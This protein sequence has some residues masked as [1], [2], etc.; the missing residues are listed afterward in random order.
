[1][2]IRPLAIVERMHHR[3]PSSL[4]DVDKPTFVGTSRGH[5]QINRSTPDNAKSRTLGERVCNADTANEHQQAAEDFGEP[6]PNP[7][8]PIAKDLKRSKRVFLVWLAGCD[9][10]RSDHYTE[11]SPRPFRSTTQPLTTI[12]MTLEA[13]STIEMFISRFF[14]DQ[15]L[16]T[17]FAARAMATPAV[18]R[19]LVSN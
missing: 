5:L 16:K 8:K 11:T 18:R 15:L 1:M 12:Q 17:M 4:S 6:N 7:Q 10:R 2:S 13:R 9:Q 3:T 14:S 19:N